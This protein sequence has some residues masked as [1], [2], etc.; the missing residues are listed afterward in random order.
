M[1]DGVGFLIGELARLGGV[2]VKTVRFYSDEGLVPPVGRNHAGQRV[3]DVRALARLELVRT[4]RELDVDLATVRRLLER[5]VT[6]AEIAAVHAEALDA[7]IRTLR[8][9]RAVLRAVARRGSGPEEL[10]IMHELARLSAEERNAIVH[11]FID[12]TFGGLEANPAFVAMMRSA[13]PELPDDP[14]PE[15]V[16]AWIELAG[17]VRDEEFRAAVRRMAEYQAEQGEAELHGE[18]SQLI[19]E[20]VG[21]AREAGVAPE[22]AEGGAMVDELVG[23]YAE[24][25]GVVDTP[26]YRRDVLRRVEVA[27]DPRAAR[28][29]ALLGKINGWPAQPDLVPV[30][31]WFVAALRAH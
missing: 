26:A 8:L 20:R 29:W 30:F 5:G 28:Y 21:A 9:R 3:Y 18:L 31:D 14:E 27:N 25:F 1:D 15:Q 22:S 11:E 17:L 2:S 16:E 10:K 7:Q 24:T 4:L 6:L 23:R 19:I 13:M 12:A